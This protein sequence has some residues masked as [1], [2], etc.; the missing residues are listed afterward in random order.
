[1]EDGSFLAADKLLEVARFYGFDGWFINQETEGGDAKTAQ[2]MKEFLIYLQQHKP[3]GMQI[4]WYDSM[5]KD[6]GI[7][8]QNA[9]TDQNSSFLQDGKTRV[10]DSMF[11]NFWWRDQQSSNNKAQ[12]LGSSPYDL[13][14]GIDVEANGTSTKVAWDGIF[15]EGKAPLTSLGIY[16]PDWAFKTAATMEEFYQKENEFWVG[17]SQ[18]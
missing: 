1:R 2:K 18:N 6:G 11:L 7:R 3:E 10:S 15:P 9:L 17:K 16:R 12:E 14:T 4:M 8:W 13:Y 5:T